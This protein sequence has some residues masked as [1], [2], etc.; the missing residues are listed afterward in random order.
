MAQSSTSAPFICSGRA[1]NLLSHVYQSTSSSIMVL[2]VTG[3]PSGGCIEIVRSRTKPRSYEVFT[4]MQSGAS[5]LRLSTLIFW[6][7]IVSY[8]KL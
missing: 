6:L 8:T 7:R 1:L 4:Y 5:N 2:H 3:D